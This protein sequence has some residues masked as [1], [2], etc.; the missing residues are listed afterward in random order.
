[1]ENI[2]EL[3]ETEL[4]QL[5]AKLDEEFRYKVKLEEQDKV[6]WEPRILNQ[7]LRRS[8]SFVCSD[9]HRPDNDRPKP[10]S[11]TPSPWQCQSQALRQ[12]SLVPRFGPK[13]Y[14]INN[15]QV[16]NITD[17]YLSGAS[18]QALGLCYDPK[19]VAS[20]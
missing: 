5:K 6:V 1:M 2:D 18:T 4:G 17:K 16:H 14:Y 20:F 10:K 19:T 11:V 15:T 3:R 8:S 12:L 7:R 9:Y 13:Q